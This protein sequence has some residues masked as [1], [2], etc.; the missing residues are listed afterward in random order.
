MCYRI[1]TEDEYEIFSA[2]EQGF[3]S[4][5]IYAWSD[6]RDRSQSEA[7]AALWDD[8]ISFLQMGGLT[9]EEEDPDYILSDDGRRVGVAQYY[10]LFGELP[11][12]AEERKAEVKDGKLVQ[13]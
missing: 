3:Y 2:S 9:P 7:L 4:S 6:V 11:K 8:A 1:L 10:S 13:Q 5:G 12:N